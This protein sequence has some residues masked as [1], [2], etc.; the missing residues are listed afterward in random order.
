MDIDGKKPAK[1]QKK[2][3]RSWGKAI[4]GAKPSKQ[5]VAVKAWLEGKRGAAGEAGVAG[6]LIYK[7]MAKMFAILSLRSQ[8]FVILKSDPHLA[9]MLR[10]QYQGVGHR[11]HLDRRFWICVDFNSDV[12]LKEIKRLIDQSYDL[13]AA[14]LTRAQQAALD[15]LRK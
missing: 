8:E 5:A 6:V 10:A 7:V 12:P 9:E 3:G 1:K 13:V 14:K 11:S 4:A 2:D 15:G